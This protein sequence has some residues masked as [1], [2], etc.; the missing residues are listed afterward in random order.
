MSVSE[1]RDAWT[2]WLCPTGITRINY[3]KNIFS[4]GDSEYE[5]VIE[6]WVLERG[7]HWRDDQ[8]EAKKLEEKVNRGHG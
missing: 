4:L 7:C 6:P 2:Q 5:T 1:P 8:A 3:I